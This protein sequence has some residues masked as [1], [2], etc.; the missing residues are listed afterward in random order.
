[1]PRACH[2]F[3]HFRKEILCVSFATA[4]PEEVSIAMWD[5]IVKGKHLAAHD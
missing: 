5:A 1:M 3:Y 4:G 2:R